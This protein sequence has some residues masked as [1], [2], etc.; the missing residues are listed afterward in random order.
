MEG[1]VSPSFVSDCDIQI[2]GTDVR[3][4]CEQSQGWPHRLMANQFLE[5]ILQ[6]TKR[7][8]ATCEAGREGFPYLAYAPCDTGSFAP[9][10]LSHTAACKQQCCSSRSQA[11]SVPPS[12]WPGSSPKAGAGMSAAGEGEQ[13]KYQEKA[14]LV[15]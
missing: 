11:G 12:G 1:K 13:A 14:V 3:S 6:A 5:Q 9:L 4:R 2:T 15:Q 7:S 8:G 10:P